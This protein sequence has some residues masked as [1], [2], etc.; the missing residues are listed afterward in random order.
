MT[1]PR[2][3]RV[4]LCHASQD[5]RVVR[6]L[7]S[8][9]S[10]KTWIEPWLDE[11]NLLPGQNWELEIESA[12]ESSDVVI[13][14][15]S[16]NSVSKEGYVQRE[17]KYVLDFALEK[18]DDSIFIIPLRLDNCEIPRRLRR[19]QYA[20]F[21]PDSSIDRSI[22]RLLASLHQRA[23][24]LNIKAGDTQTLDP[25]AIPP[26]IRDRK[27]VGKVPDNING[28]CFIDVDGAVIDLPKERQFTIGRYDAERNAKPDL[29]LSKWD[30]GRTVSRKHAIVVFHNGSY[31]LQSPFDALNGTFVNGKRVENVMQEINDGDK[32]NFAEVEFRFRF[33]PHKFT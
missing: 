21:F 16:S 14:C 30:K 15:C 13:V 9:L 7:Y 11:E 20:D 33:R 27:T 28:P 5:K 8:R 2:K 26:S 17:L 32:L 25:A 24:H 19:W 1:E 12:V 29:D 6:E 10:A 31:Y 22:Q 4:F 3:L 18:P 23:H